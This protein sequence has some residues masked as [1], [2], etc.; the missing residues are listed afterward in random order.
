MMISVLR[1]IRQKLIA[2]GKL[3]QYL[4]YAVGEIILVVVG[5]LIA[6]KINDLQK[7][8]QDR[9]DE[10]VY[11]AR[12]VEDLKMDGEDMQESNTYAFR[13]IAISTWVLAQLG[14]SSTSFEPQFMLKKASDNAPINPKWTRDSLGL[15]LTRLLDART[16]D[17]NDV[18]YQEMVATSKIQVIQ[19]VPLRTSINQH[20]ATA[21]KALKFNSEIIE[22]QQEFLEALKSIGITPNTA[23]AAP[24][25][26]QKLQSKEPVL[27]SLKYVRDMALRHLHIFEQPEHGLLDKNS[28]LL[29]QIEKQ[30]E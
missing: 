17:H 22:G 5:I 3:K 23:R 15:A 13:R 20:Y 18:T 19:D 1:K 11:L 27:V 16:F 26:Y 7:E 2:E 12:L 10:Q 21:K 4:A 29:Q 24:S 30:L 9:R 8:R 28:V 6:L 14:D 25:L